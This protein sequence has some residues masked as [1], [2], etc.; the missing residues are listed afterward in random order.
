MQ[1]IDRRQNPKAKSLGN[2]QRFLRRIKSQIRKAVN[3]AIEN[4]SVADVDSGEKV[5]VTTSDI[6]E[7][8]FGF[9]STEGDRSYVIPGNHDYQRGDRI[10]KPSGGGSGSG[11]G[12]SPDGDGEDAFVFMLTRDEFLDLFF[13]DLELPNLAKRKLKSI[14][15]TK[16]NR[17]GYANDGSP[18]RLNKSQTMRRSLARRIALKRPRLHEL[19]RLEE[20]LEAAR[21]EGKDAEHDEEVK[22]LVR[23]IEQLRYRMQ[24]VPFL[25]PVDLR[26][27]RFEQTPKPTTQAV[28]FCLMDTSASMTES[29]K[30]L[31][32]RFYILLHLFL[33]RHYRA[34]ELVF[35]R[36]T[37]TAAEV[38]E[39][40]FFHGRETGGTVVSSALEEMLRIV[41]ERYPVQDWNI[42]AAQ[43]S[44]GHNF[45]HDMPRTIALLQHEILDLCQYYAYI[46]V[47]EEE[48]SYTSALWNGYSQLDSH[49]QFARAKV[50]DPTEIY[51]VF[52]K[53]FASN[54]QP[55]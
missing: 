52:H 6:G 29:L 49:P 33:T 43:A 38:D 2:R 39:E 42:Y 54:R 46:E 44:D 48:S 5:S 26:Y 14:T 25:D 35:I 13:E 1:V 22:G 8:K 16:W 3:E 31:A 18:Q 30:D 50:L 40:T 23:R 12:G 17:A 41:R 4:R 36:H 11:S 53:L 10:R 55:S 51:P 27:N 19:N 9:D 7:P 45:D 37:Y 21:A 47:G 34:V 24:A 15:S 20:E 32:K 28:M